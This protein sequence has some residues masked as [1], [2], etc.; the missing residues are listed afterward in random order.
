MVF[1]DVGDLVA[2]GACECDLRVQKF[3]TNYVRSNNFRRRN[4]IRCFVLSRKQRDIAARFR[5]YLCSLLLQ[6]LKKVHLLHAADAHAVTTSQ[7][8]LTKDD[9]NHHIALLVRLG[10]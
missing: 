6:R 3:N 10:A 2:C 9:M 4:R 8:N 7:E 5:T 1:G